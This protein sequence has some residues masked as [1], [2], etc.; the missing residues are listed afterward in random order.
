MTDTLKKNEFKWTEEAR[1]AFEILKE[2]MTR[3]PALR[4]PDFSKPFILEAGTCGVGIGAF[5]MQERQLCLYQQG[6][7]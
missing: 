7:F 4:L 6:P 3:A 5:L 2:T 1:E